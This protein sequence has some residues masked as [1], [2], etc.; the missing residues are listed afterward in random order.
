[1]EIFQSYSR[2]FAIRNIHMNL[3]EEEDSITFE[4]IENGVLESNEMT[5]RYL[6]HAAIALK[7]TL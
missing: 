7:L 6:L 3:I 5:I 1:M 4:K 2:K